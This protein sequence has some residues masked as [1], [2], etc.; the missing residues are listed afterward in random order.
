ML[1]R[2]F[3]IS[4]IFSLY[5]KQKKIKQR[6]E[7]EYFSFR[8]CIRF[9]EEKSSSSVHPFPRLKGEGPERKASSSSALQPE[10]ASQRGVFFSSFSFPSP[11]LVS[12]AFFFLAPTSSRMKNTE[13]LY[14][15]RGGK[16]KKKKV[17]RGRDDCEKKKQ[18]KALR[19]GEVNRR[20]RSK[21]SF[22]E[23]FFFVFLAKIFFM[24]VRAGERER[25]KNDCDGGGEEENQNLDFSARNFCV[26][27]ETKRTA[28]VNH[29]FMVWRDHVT[30][31]FQRSFV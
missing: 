9:S 8:L 1:T 30:R 11:F 23:F 20:R 25:E 12:L 5:E 16:R 10:S 21:K 29:P 14:A 31:G 7:I 26:S 18:Q 2:Q 3:F 15:R 19:K 6:G 17:N 13:T 24:K 4:F 22:R 27:R 28:D